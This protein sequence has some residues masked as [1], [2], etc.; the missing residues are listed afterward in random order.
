MM[1]GALDFPLIFREEWKRSYSKNK[2]TLSW[3]ERNFVEKKP[4]F[5]L[6]RSDGQKAFT[7][8]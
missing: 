3:V 5:H 8:S 7:L 2:S 1:V 6:L 4:R